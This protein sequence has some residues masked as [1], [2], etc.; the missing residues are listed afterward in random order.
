[1]LDV[2]LEKKLGDMEL[3][4]SFK[5]P[6]GVTALFGPS[7]AGKTSLV[8]L[9]AGLLKPDKGR[10]AL[11]EKVLFDF[12]RKIDLPPEQRGVGCVFQDGRLFPHLSVKSNLLYG[13]RLVPPQRRHL[14][15]D[16]VVELMGIA[17]LLK[18]RP[19]TLSG[20]EKQR[21]AVGRALLTSPRLLL[22]DEPLAS[23]DQA[24]KQE[25]LPFLARLP[26]ELDLPIIYVSH[27]PREV[28]FLADRVV[29]L[30]QGKITSL[31]SIS[32]SMEPLRHSFANGLVKKLR[33]N[34]LLI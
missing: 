13:M 3:Q 24:R 17:H 11:G 25:V 6:P 10:I 18:R 29:K 27:S 16:E 32:E 14:G 20:G 23:L 28:E 7:G 34:P 8:N 22:M 21:V 12:S 31:E 2:R 33:H 15:L 4:A 26:K 5:A 30:S 1:M 9:I 19:A